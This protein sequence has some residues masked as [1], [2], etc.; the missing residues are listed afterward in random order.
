MLFLILLSISITSLSVVSLFLSFDREECDV[1][2]LFQTSLI[3]LVGVSYYAIVK[4]CR[5][6]LLF[7]LSARDRNNGYVPQSATRRGLEVVEHANSSREMDDVDIEVKIVGNVECVQGLYAVDYDCNHF[8]DKEESGNRSNKS[9]S[10]SDFDLSENSIRSMIPENTSDI[11]EVYSV[12]KAW[13]NIYG[14]GLAVFCLVYSFQMHNIHGNIM[15]C[16]SFWGVSLEEYHGVYR[17]KVSM[18]HMSG[19]WL[20]KYRRLLIND[21]SRYLWS[22]LLLTMYIFSLC[23]HTAA[24]LLLD[25]N[26]ERLTLVTMLC[27]SA[28][29]VIVTFTMKY[30]KRPHNMVD[31]IELSIPVSTMISV[32]VLCVI[33]STSPDCIHSL[34]VNEN[35]DVIIYP[36][37]FLSMFLSPILA[38]CTLIAVLSANDGKRSFDVATTI[39]C[40]ASVK[41]YIHSFQAAHVIIYDIS[42]I[43]IQF[44]VFGLILF[45]SGICHDVDVV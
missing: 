36:L 34:F 16:L 39:L 32:C 27:N 12:G 42:F 40:I 8:A 17:S 44:V 18:C 29:P 38:M 1:F 30:M 4:G 14:L 7:L 19:S 26:V 9:G 15:L 3:I 35:E 45:R 20:S 25:E 31:T 28:M 21:S 10:L 11:G 23:V 13:S 2:I 24:A 22:P 37:Q 6:I 33:L 43:I 41:L 5:Y